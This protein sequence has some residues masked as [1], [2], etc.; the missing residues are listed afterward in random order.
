MNDVFINVCKQVKKKNNVRYLKCEVDIFDGSA[1]IQDR[2]LV[3]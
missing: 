2:E 3:A 1:K